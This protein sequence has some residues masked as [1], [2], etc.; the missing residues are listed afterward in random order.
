MYV[1]SVDLLMIVIISILL[2]LL[3]IG[4]INYVRLIIK[5]KIDY[6]IDN[7]VNAQNSDDA[8]NNHDEKKNKEI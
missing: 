4:M 5:E 1:N 6:I 8:H 2:I 7:I 3:S